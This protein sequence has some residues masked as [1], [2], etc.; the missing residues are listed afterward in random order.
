MLKI[1]CIGQ[2]CSGKTTLAKFFMKEHIHNF[3]IKQADPIYKSIE[4]LGYKKHRAFMQE[5]GDLAKKHFGLKVFTEA[6]TKSVKDTEIDIIN[7]D[8]FDDGYSDN[9]LII[10][11][12]VRFDWELDNV[13]ELGFITVS[14]ICPAEIRKQRADRQG[15]EFLEEHNSEIEIPNLIPKADWIID[16]SDLT[17]DRFREKALEILKKI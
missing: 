2:Q 9:A 5:F 15:F 8:L 14:I 1:A 3:H 13:K 10:N 11:D 7:R 12:D 17:K 16:N 4:A 6:F